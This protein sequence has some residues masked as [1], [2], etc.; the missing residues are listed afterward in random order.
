MTRSRQN[1]LPSRT[2]E[3]KAAWLQ[4]LAGVRRERNRR[5]RMLLRRLK[6]GE[7]LPIQAMAKAS[8][9][10]T[11]QAP[12]CGR[13][14][15]WQAKDL[16]GVIRRSLGGGAIRRRPQALSASPSPSFYK[17]AGLFNDPTLWISSPN[18]DEAF[19]YQI[20]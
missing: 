4:S 2:G 12:R 13:A 9:Y 3:A 5:L 18:H 7:G 20:L 19:L 15:L 8:G 14:S 16:G 11:R 1:D 6:A 10:R 17:V